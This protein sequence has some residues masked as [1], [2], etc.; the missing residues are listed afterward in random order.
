MLQYS[1]MICNTYTYMYIHIHDDD[2][3]KSLPFISE[4]P[5]SILLI[6]NFLTL[7][8]HLSYG[9]PCTLLQAH[10]NSS[11]CTLLFRFIHYLHYIT[12]SN[13]SHIRFNSLLFL[14]YQ[15]F[16]SHFAFFNW[17]FVIFSHSLPKF[18][19]H[20]TYEP[21]YFILKIIS[22]TSNYSRPNLYDDLL[23]W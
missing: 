6:Q 17:L 7:Y 20:A 8:T 11:I 2:D 10:L 13:F 19:I 22:V 21:N 16:L 1:Y 5:S 14:M 18:R 4:Q 15:V 3:D 12:Y 23:F 9:L